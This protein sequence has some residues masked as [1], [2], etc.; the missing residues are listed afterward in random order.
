M[1]IDLTQL[2]VLWPINYCQDPR[3]LNAIQTT[4]T[5]SCKRHERHYSPRSN[6]YLTMWTILQETQLSQIGCGTFHV[7]ENFAKVLESCE[8][9]PWVGIVLC[10]YLVLFEIFSMP[11]KFGLGVIQGH[12]LCHHSVDH[13]DFLPVCY[14]NCCSTLYHFFSYLTFKNIVTISES[15]NTPLHSTL[16]HNFSKCCPIFRTISLFD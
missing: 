8:I 2:I 9:T 16:R 12:W 11:L 1:G 6:W 3:T 13:I 7:V 5:I 15:K 10:V 14:R 4:I